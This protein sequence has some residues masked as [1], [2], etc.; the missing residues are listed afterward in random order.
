M[1][2]P[3]GQHRTHEVVLLDMD[4]EQDRADMECNEREQQV[5]RQLVQAV[6]LVRVPFRPDR[7][8][9]RGKAM[10]SLPVS[11]VAIWKAIRANSA[12]TEQP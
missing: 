8:A 11:P 5:G 1:G 6:E 7:R 3:A 2:F 10:S 4:I 12:K 9:D